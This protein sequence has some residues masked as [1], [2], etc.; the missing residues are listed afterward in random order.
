MTKIDQKLDCKGLS[1]PMP[2]LKLAKTMKAMKSGEVLEMEGTDP[3]SKQDVPG[4]CKKMGHKLLGVKE[5][6]GV[7]KYYIQHK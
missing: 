2:I 6:T 5:E 1:C 4:W 7:F 3:G